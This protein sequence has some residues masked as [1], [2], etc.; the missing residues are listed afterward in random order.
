MIRAEN[1]TC[2]WEFC[3]LPATVRVTVDTGTMAAAGV[4]CRF[5]KAVLYDRLS[6]IAEPTVEAIS[7]MTYECP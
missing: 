1:T 2:D 6:F 5:H 7:P 3:L 4:A